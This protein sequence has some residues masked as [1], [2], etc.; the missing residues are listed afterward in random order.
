M[1]T[2]SVEFPREKV[3]Y[4]EKARGI[5]TLADTGSIRFITENATIEE[6]DTFVLVNSRKTLIIILPVIGSDTKKIQI[7]SAYANVTHFIKTTGVDYLL[8]RDGKG[9]QN[10]RLGVDGKHTFV[11]KNN[12][13]FLC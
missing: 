1:T 4:M 3:I 12:V 2:S 5:N 6:T 9:Q 10:C 7:H 13:W 11:G 8:S